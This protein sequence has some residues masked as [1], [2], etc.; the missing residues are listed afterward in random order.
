MKGSFRWRR[1]NVVYFPQIGY[2]IVVPGGEI[3]DL[4]ADASLEQQFASD[5]A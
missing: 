3:V 4:L 2:L 1:L 5:Q